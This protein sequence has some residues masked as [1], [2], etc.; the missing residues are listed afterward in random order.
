VEASNSCARTLIFGSFLLLPF[1]KFFSM[2]LFHSF[3]LVFYCFFFIFYLVFY[4]P[5]FSPSFSLFFV[6][7]AHVVSSLAYPN[8]LGNKMLGCGCGINFHFLLR[9][10]AMNKRYFLLQL[11]YIHLEKPDTHDICAH[12]NMPHMTT[13]HRDLAKLKSLLPPNFLFTQP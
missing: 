1:V 6:F 3:D 9:I 2:P 7:L 13:F 12:A 8:L 5:L 10:D 11:I 4:H